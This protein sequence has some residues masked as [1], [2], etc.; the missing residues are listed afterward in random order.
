M[1]F[2][3]SITINGANS[4]KGAQFK[5]STFVI[6]L[7][8]DKFVI[9]YLTTT[10]PYNCTSLNKCE[11]RS[12]MHQSAGM[13]QCPK[14]TRSNYYSL[15]RCI[16]SVLLLR[17]SFYPFQF[18]IETQKFTHMISQFPVSW[19]YPLIS[20]SRSPPGFTHSHLYEVPLPKCEGDGKGLQAL[21]VFL[22]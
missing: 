1:P 12:L 10:L 11:F 3:L 5:F 16:R 18:G 15:F 8:Q 19:F 20:H 17:V 13:E 14:L 7:V 4:I 6:L 9:S 21:F 22:H 2:V